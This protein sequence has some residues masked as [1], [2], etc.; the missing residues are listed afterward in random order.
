M[1]TSQS[2]GVTANRIQYRR[3][4]AF[5][6]DLIEMPRPYNMIAGLV[7]DVGEFWKNPLIL[8]DFYLIDDLIVN[9]PKASRA[10]FVCV[11]EEWVNSYCSH[12]GDG[13]P[14]PVVGVGFKDTGGAKFNLHF[15]TGEKW[16]QGDA[17]AIYSVVEYCPKP[18]ADD[19]DSDY[20]V[21]GLATYGKHDVDVAKTSLPP[22]LSASPWWLFH[23]YDKPED[24]F[25]FNYK[26]KKMFA[27]PDG[28]ERRFAESCDYS[29]FYDDWEK[30]TETPHIV[31]LR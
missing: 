9:F 4:K 20:D 15:K 1:A 19:S 11:L 25:L 13:P 6:D 22:V 14:R 26:D 28:V 5:S 27:G 8:D 29:E 2:S 10:V 24:W 30:K 23:K 17:A 21:I 12:P 3:I 16:V 31:W 7:A 18:D